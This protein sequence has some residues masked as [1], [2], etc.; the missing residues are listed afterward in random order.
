MLATLV[1]A[2]VLL[3]PAEQ[4]FDERDRRLLRELVFGALRWKRR[5]EAVIE[6]ASGRDLATIDE[7]L[8]AVLVVAAFQLLFLDRVPAHAA[9]SE[10]VDEARRLRGR[11]AAGFVNAVLRR[12][13][14]DPRCE[15]FPLTESDPL[16]RLAIETSYPDA[17]VERW[18]NR[19]GSSSAR[20]LLEAG[21][22]ARPL[23]LLAFRDRG[24]R[25]KLAADLAAEG[26]LTEPSSLA[27]DGLVVIDGNALRT[28]SFQRGDL[29]VQDEASQ[30][31]GLIPPP[32]AGERILDAAAAP[33]GK[34]WVL[35]AHEP[36]VEIVAAELS[37]VR[38]RILTENLQRLGRQ[39]PLVVADATRP[40]WRVPFERVVLDAS[41]SGTGT[42]RRHPEL[43]WRFRTEELERLA[44]ESSR[45]LAA[46][47]GS[48]EPGGV[49]VHV[50]CSIEAEENEAVIAAFLA[51]SREFRAEP[52]DSAHVPA[53]EPG[54]TGT[55]G[56]LLLPRGGHDGFTVSLLRRG[57]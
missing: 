13:A 29:Y 55:G 44:G 3:A 56:L 42:L 15:A 19:F 52:V 39:L 12:I 36:S 4:P 26:V 22:G 14:R 17:L 41:C 8:R 43:K 50:T 7:P 37:L 21:N 2:E 35:V 16:R 40:P 11:G 9:V 45:Q 1:P 48:V 31:A 28:G 6:V 18:W 33:G 47:A 23:H 54:R 38:M 20:E 57:A 51:C 34:S 32:R 46:L 24:G 27:P 5:L 49:L 10:A 25:A 53:S 30:A